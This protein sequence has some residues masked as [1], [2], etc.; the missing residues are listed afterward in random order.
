[1][2]KKGYD[3]Y[4]IDLSDYA[5]NAGHKE[6]FPLRNKTIQGSIHE[7]QTFENE[8]FDFLY[9]N[10]VFEHVP[11]EVCNELASETLRIAKS[12]AILWVGLVL[13]MNNEFQPQGFN[14]LDPDKTHINIRPKIWWDE[15]M[16]KVGWQ[17]NNKFDNK[18]RQ[19]KLIEDGYSF[20]AEYGWHSICYN[21]D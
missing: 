14:P 3:A 19:H 17:I 4:G 12:G 20:F 10:Q 11:A 9:S 21:K 8:S 2:I 6:Y 1:M 5:I 15:I 7:L 18:F 16:T 13:D